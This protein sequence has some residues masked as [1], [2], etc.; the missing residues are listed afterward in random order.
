MRIKDYKSVIR[1]FFVKRVHIPVLAVGHTGLG[2]T[3]A[4]YQVFWEMHLKYNCV[5]DAERNPTTDKDGNFKLKDVL[6]VGYAYIN[7][8]GMEAT[9]LMGY[10]S[11]NKEKGVTEFLPPSWLKVVEQFPMGILVIDEVNRMDLQVRQAYMQFL[12]RREIGNV[13]LPDGWVIVQ[14]ANPPE[15][16]Y[17]VSDWDDALV[18]RACDVYIEGDLA[19]WLDYAM[20]EWTSPMNGQ[21]GFS[22]RILATANRLTNKGLN[23]ECK[24]SIQK[25]PTYAGLEY[26]ELLEESEISKLG[27]EVARSVMAGVIGWDGADMWAAS[28]NNVK[29]K[30][31]LEQILNGEKPDKISQD[32]LLDVMFDFLPLLKENAVKVA[33]A[34]YLLWKVLPE[35]VKM[36]FANRCYPYMLKHAKAYADFKKDHQKWCVDNMVMMGP[37]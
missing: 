33:D 9:D 5:L 18:R 6:E 23:R 32:V 17:H 4:P 22:P 30:R 29:S 21:K 11:P 31:V 16:G 15:D 26:A 24:A 2:K 25:K 8:T 28:L 19:S 10:P 36:V 3:A 35:D 1:H 34:A 14:T 7:M 12:E 13:K 20:N 27:A 37:I